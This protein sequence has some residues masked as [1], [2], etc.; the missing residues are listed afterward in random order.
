MEFP[1]ASILT[2]VEIFLC[3]ST[4]DIWI[5]GL[6]YTINR[7]CLCFYN[8]V[9]SPSSWLK[10]KL[11]FFMS[12]ALH[13]Y[14][15][16]MSLVTVFFMSQNATWIYHDQVNHILLMLWL[17]KWYSHL[18]TLFPRPF[19]ILWYFIIYIFVHVNHQVKSFWLFSTVFKIKTKFLPCTL[20]LCLIRY[21]LPLSASF[22]V[23]HVKALFTSAIMNFFQFFY[24]Y[25][26]PTS[27]PSIHT[28]QSVRNIFSWF[29]PHFCLSSQT[30]I[31]VSD[32]SFHQPPFSYP[33]YDSFHSNIH[34]YLGAFSALVFCLMSIF[35][36]RY[37]LN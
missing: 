3:I 14:S 32:L 1:F 10:S 30:C 36:L 34:F 5:Y 17:V 25:H 18:L 19:L 11:S 24:L 16:S 23:T 33:E 15:H 22:D 13:I 27:R 8:T 21:C 28:V 20:K 37:S 29:L 26:F 12:S 6:Q 9:A 35:P 7:E 2:D 4:K 31:C